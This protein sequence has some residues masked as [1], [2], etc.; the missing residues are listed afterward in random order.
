MVLIVCVSFFSRG[1]GGCRDD[2]FWEQGAHNDTMM[3]QMALQP[4]QKHRRMRAMRV[5]HL[6][7]PVLQVDAVDE[8]QFT[9]VGYVLKQPT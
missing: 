8:P 2:S 4:N 3:P 5:F 7:I 1:G 9:Q 6:G